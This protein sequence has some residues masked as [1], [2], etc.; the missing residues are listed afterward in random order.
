MVHPNIKLVVSRPS[1]ADLLPAHTPRAIEAFFDHWLSLPREGLVPTLQDYLDHA[2]PRLQPFVA[3]A[4]VTSPTEMRVRLMGTGYVDL[5]GR[6]ATGARLSPLYAAPIRERMSSAV[7]QLVTRPVG[8]LC[9]RSIRT[10]GGRLV[11]SPSICLPLVGRDGGAK[12]ILTYGLVSPDNHGLAETELFHLT[13][14]WTLT[15]WL[16]LGAGVP[17]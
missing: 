16:N 11:E 15:A 6:D 2:P 4:E 1:A 14:D 13:L 10:F 3:I 9:V 5:V 8:Y 7:W 12:F 17:E